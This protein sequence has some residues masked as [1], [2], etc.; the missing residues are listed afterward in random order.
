[1]RGIS[2]FIQEMKAMIT[3]KKIIIPVIAILFIPILYSGTFLWAFWDPYEQMD[4]LPVAVVNEDQGVV[5]NDEE[6]HVGNDL[7]DQLEDNEGFAWDFVDKS[8]GEKGLENRE[9]YM[10]IE[11]PA[12]FSERAT[13]LLEDEPTKLELNYIPNES[14]NFLAG[15]IGEKAI[16]SIKEEVAHELTATFAETL[17][18]NV[19]ELADGLT[20]ASDGASKI[21]DGVLELNDGAVTLQDNMEILANNSIAFKEGLEASNSGSKEIQSGMTAL[22]DGFSEMKA[23]Q[24]EL[25]AGATEA[26]A[27]T[28]EISGGL[29]KSL[30][31]VQTAQDSIPQLTEGSLKLSAGAQQLA[32]STE[33]WK[34]GADQTEAGASELAAGIEQLNQELQPIL[35]SLPEPQR[36]QLEASLTSLVEGGKQVNG[37]VEQ[38]TD[39]AVEINDGAASLSTEMNN[40]HEGQLALQ[41]GMDELEE[42]QK[43]LVEGATELSGG[44]DKLVDGL[45][46]FGDKITEA[47]VGSNELL[48]GSN[49]LSTGIGELASGSVDLE[50]GANQ[51]ADGSIK[52]VNGFVD[53]SDGTNELATKLTDAATETSDI[54]GNDDVYDMFADPV[55]VESKKENEVPNYGTGMAPYLL[56][57][58]LFVGATILSII[59]PLHDPAREPKNAFSWFFSK[60]GVLLGIG[61]IQAIVADVVLLTGL[62]LEVQ[63]VPLF[64]LFS[65]LT[66]ITF[67]TMI[68]FLVTSF[69]NIGRFI[70]I[71]ILIMQLATSAGT[72]PLEMIPDALQPLHAFVPMSYT[73]SGFKAVISSGD[74]GFMW[75]NATTLLIFIAVFSIGTLLYFATQ[76]KRK[77]AGKAVGQEKSLEA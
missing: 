8:V 46:L 3:N 74:F 77:Y 70:A 23:G 45:Q 55:T 18:D 53:L 5:Y 9:Y 72:F 1:M 43:Q 58:G 19:D 27:G 60:F 20:E 36:K 14:Y 65:I 42:G 52:L 10:M 11:I 29:Q 48:E 22:H 33:E 54:T 12:D 69:N 68:Q 30:E 35:G 64:I 4:R 49:Q 25:L 16:E 50:D 41:S 38:L 67:I 44:Q 56:S 37:G 40:L 13:T 66:S 28:K 32:E 17:F 39:A 6:L 76:F 75:E 2:L 26:Q 47:Q 51:L 63:S 21:D 57:L 61:V 62:G 71:I 73:V 7:V 31:G 59:Y 15:Q 24:E 34:Q